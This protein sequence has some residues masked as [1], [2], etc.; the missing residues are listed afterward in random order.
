MIRLL[1][2]FCAKR[3]F[4]V[5]KRSKKVMH[6]HFC[7]VT[8]FPAYNPS[9]TKSYETSSSC[10]I[11]KTRIRQQLLERSIHITPPL[12]NSRISLKRGAIRSRHCLPQLHYLASMYY[13]DNCPSSKK[14]IAVTCQSGV[15]FQLMTF[16]YSSYNCRTKRYE[17]IARQWLK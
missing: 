9:R 5:V 2:Y 17:K 4:L 11:Y 14:A 16:T 3:Q 6:K 8:V 12:C 10:N 13:C 15:I 1:R 7:L